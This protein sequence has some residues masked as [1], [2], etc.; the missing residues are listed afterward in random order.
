MGDSWRAGN[1]TQPDFS[2]WEDWARRVVT[3]EPAPAGFAA[4]AAL[5][6]LEDGGSPDT[7]ALAA[8][9]AIGIPAPTQLAFLVDCQRHRLRDLLSELDLVEAAIAERPPNSPL[10][11]ELQRRLKVSDQVLGQAGQLAASPRASPLPPNLSS[12]AT[13]WFPSFQSQPSMQPKGEH[14]VQVLGAT[15][16]F[17]L[18]VATVLFEAYGIRHGSGLPRFM[19]VLGLQC[20]LGGA[21]TICWRTPRLR[22]MTT[23]YLTVTALLFPL[24]LTAAA[25]FLHLG[26]HGL[27]V[28]P[29]LAVGGFACA[30]VYGCLAMGLRSPNY[31]LLAS[32]GLL[33]GWTCASLDLLGRTWVP[34]GFVVLTASLLAVDAMSG[35]GGPSE[36]G[37]QRVAQAFGLWAAPLAGLAA[38]VAGIWA[39]AEITPG[40]QGSLTSS[41]N[42]TPP[43]G[44]LIHDAVLPTTLAGLAVVLLVASA[45]PAARFWIAPAVVAGSSALLTLSW[46]LSWGAAGAAWTLALTAVVIAMGARALQSTTSQPRPVLQTKSTAEPVLRAGPP[47]QVARGFDSATFLRGVATVEALAV[48]FLPQTATWW[49]PLVLAIAASASVLLARGSGQGEWALAVAPSGRRHRVLFGLGPCLG[50]GGGPR[51]QPRRTRSGLDVE[52]VSHRARRPR[53]LRPTPP[54]QRLVRFDVHG[55]CGSGCDGRCA[56]GQHPSLDSR[57]RAPGRLLVDR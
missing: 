8:F 19:V 5:V 15:G 16:A 20:V 17:L 36:A 33:T 7:A 23:I 56:R 34:I 28:T 43:A 38:V 12:E 45:R 14:G 32:A 52:P 57:R 30:L 53:P 31:G 48:L 44:I 46:T 3:D 13:R 6:S 39:V 42:C 9:N 11:A 40:C 35:R 1:E 47:G 25:V 4:Q 22:P 10:R 55:R 37:P 21:T 50:H 49:A 29:G 18:I 26:R 2:N 41:L 27:S 54:H 51:L 24:L